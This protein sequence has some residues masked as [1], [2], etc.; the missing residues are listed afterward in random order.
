MRNL[1]T[2][3]KTMAYQ[4]FKVLR[5]AMF[6]GDFRMGKVYVANVL[7]KIAIGAEL[8]QKTTHLGFQI[9]YLWKR[10][11]SVGIFPDLLIRLNQWQKTLIFRSGKVKIVRWLKLKLSANK[12]MG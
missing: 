12:G 6:V 10:L 1:V 8:C 5:L 11:K 2:P 3:Q 7:E 9:Y 4:R